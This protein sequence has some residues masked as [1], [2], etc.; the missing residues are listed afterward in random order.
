MRRTGP[1]LLGFDRKLGARLVAGADEAGR[2]PLAG[3]L[4][5]AGVLLDYGCLR[6]HRVRPLAF[7]N[8]S[9]QCTEAQREELFRAVVGCAERIAVRVISPREIDTNGLHRS[10]LAGLRAM[11]HAP[12]SSGGRGGTTSCGGIACWRR[13]SGPAVTSSTWSCGAAGS[14]S[15]LR[16]RPRRTRPSSTRSRWSARRSSGACAG[17]RRRGWHA[18]RS[19]TTWTSR[20][21]SWRSAVAVSSGWRT[22]SD[23][24]P[25]RGLRGALPRERRSAPP[26]R[27]RRRRGAVGSR[28]PADRRGDPPAR[29][30]P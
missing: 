18:T 25:A 19:W 9:K 29:Q 11:L 26:V 17:P 3:P 7:L 12:Q 21:T 28:A 22:R 8:D 24:V 10:N 27:L 13:T 2:G 20:S 14:S 23:L 16:S 1:K 30:L 4:V 5:V 6:D 15:S